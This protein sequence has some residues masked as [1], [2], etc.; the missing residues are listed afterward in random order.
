VNIFSLL[1]ATFESWHAPIR[2]FNQNYENRK[3]EWEEQE[4][5]E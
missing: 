3:N 1:L 5:K 4:N 2:E